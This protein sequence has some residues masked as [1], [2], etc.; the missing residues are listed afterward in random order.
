MFKRTLL[1][2]A[3][4]GFIAAS[5]LAITPSA[6]SAHSPGGYGPGQPSI[7]F[8]FG[9]PGWSLQFGNPQPHFK[10]HKVCAPVVKKVKWWDNYGYPHWS[11]V[12]VGQKCSFGGPGFGGPG[13]GG[14]GP[15]WGGPGPGPGPGWGGNW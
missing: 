11:Q 5:A 3:A 1:A 15:G 4:A 12:V 7:A 10:P 2:T 13:F 14:P 6:A 8:Q 9:G